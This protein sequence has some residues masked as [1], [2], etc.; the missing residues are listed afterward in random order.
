MTGENKAFPCPRD[1]HRGFSGAGEPELPVVLII[2]IFFFLSEEHNFSD[3]LP[4]QIGTQVRQV[5][6]SVTSPIPSQR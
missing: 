4:E 1:G 6:I 2:I 3:S 5:P